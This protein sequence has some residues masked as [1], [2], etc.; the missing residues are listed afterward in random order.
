LFDC[1]EGG[2]DEAGEE[3]G[4]CVCCGGHGGGGSC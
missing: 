3:F 1:Q 4:G 2:A